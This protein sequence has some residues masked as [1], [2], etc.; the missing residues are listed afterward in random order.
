MC[1]L[2]A[3]SD[4]RQAH[5][6]TSWLW[7]L[8]GHSRAACEISS[9][10][11]DWKPARPG[12]TDPWVRLAYLVPSAEIF[13]PSSLDRERETS[14]R[15]ASCEPQLPSVPFACPGQRGCRSALIMSTAIS[16]WCSYKR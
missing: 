1:N 6:P 7:G 8:E 5:R 16:A 11:R 4:S 10:F 14:L 15:L 3:P 9:R 12:E 2:G 13:C